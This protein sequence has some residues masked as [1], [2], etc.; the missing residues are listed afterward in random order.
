MFQHNVTMF[1]ATQTHVVSH[2]IWHLIDMHEIALDSRHS[3]VTCASQAQWSKEK[4][5]ANYLVW[6]SHLKNIFIRLSINTSPH[7]E[8]YKLQAMSILLILRRHIGLMP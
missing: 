7:F 8:P 5:K 2:V 3:K 4:P 1:A 6:G